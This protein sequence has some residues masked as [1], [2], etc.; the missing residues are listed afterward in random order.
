MDREAPSWAQQTQTIYARKATI[1]A[2]V[3]Y[4][5]G[6]AS[7]ILATAIAATAKVQGGIDPTLLAS[8]AAVSAG[9]SFLSTGLNASKR[10]VSYD[11]ASDILYAAIIR[12]RLDDSIAEGTVGE[13]A[14]RALD[15]LHGDSK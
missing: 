8:V 2:T 4:L 10:S 3:H 6:F 5:L 11:R 14:I 15:I 7:A 12:Y 1:W 9:F 13:A